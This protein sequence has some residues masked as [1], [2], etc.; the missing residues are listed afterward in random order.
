MRRLATP[1]SKSA[2]T[3]VDGVATLSAYKERLVGVALALRFG[4]GFE[5][6]F[7]VS[8]PVTVG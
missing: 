2:A 7:V 6:R 8:A 4:D 1:V 3:C 5:T